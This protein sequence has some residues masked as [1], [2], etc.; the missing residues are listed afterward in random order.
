MKLYNGLSPNGVRVTIFLAEKGIDIPLVPVD[1]LGG[2]PKREPFLSL[3]SLG[4]VPVL[5][6]D[7]G[8]VLTESVA[9]C[10]YIEALH[11]EPSLFGEDAKSQAHIEMWSRRM[12]LKVFGAIADFARHEFE[13]FKDR[14]PQIPA[15]A[16]ARREDFRDH[17]AWLDKEMSDGRAFVA[18]DRFSVADITGMA[19][20]LLMGFAQYEV[21]ADLPHF[22]RWASSMT[23]RSSF[24]KMPG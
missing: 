10:R 2:E 4:E 11:P 24:P 9:I 14:G 8:T 13:M 6:L 5:E 23:D 17:L 22:A 3:N 20:L 12:E 15:F 7:D 1:I 18:G 16:E 21:P 19:V